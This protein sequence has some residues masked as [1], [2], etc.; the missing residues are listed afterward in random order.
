MDRK[1]KS[2]VPARK[3]GQIY[4]QSRSPSYPPPSE[5]QNP[6]DH[7]ANNVVHPSGNRGLGHA[8]IPLSVPNSWPSHT[9]DWEDEVNG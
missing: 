2:K 9:G 3:V 7:P 8:T 5:E 1:G 6:Q 4:D